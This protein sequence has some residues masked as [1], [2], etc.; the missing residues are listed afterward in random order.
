MGACW[1]LPLLVPSE[2]REAGPRCHSLA[3]QGHR[4]GQ[5]RTDIPGRGGQGARS[6]PVSGVLASEEPHARPSAERDQQEAGLGVPP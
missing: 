1:K 6:E 5:L 2:N 4:G 3:S